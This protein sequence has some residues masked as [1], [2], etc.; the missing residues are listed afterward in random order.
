MPSKTNIFLV[1]LVIEASIATK[2]VLMADLFFLTV[3]PNS[4]SFLSNFFRVRESTKSGTGTRRW[5]VF[6]AMKT[7]PKSLDPTTVGFTFQDTPLSSSL[8]DSKKYVFSFKLEWLKLKLLLRCNPFMAISFS[9]LLKALESLWLDTLKFWY[10]PMYC[11]KT[12]SASFE[13]TSLLVAY[14]HTFFFITM[15]CLRGHIYVYTLFY[16]QPVLDS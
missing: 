9:I 2:I 1:K 14:F 6:L 12:S 13:F 3:F 8:H 7:F 4:Q 11:Y 10:P 5:V 15:Y 16:E